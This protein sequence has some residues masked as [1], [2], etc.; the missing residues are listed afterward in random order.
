MSKAETQD[1]AGS[2]I[3]CT[4]EALLLELANGGVYKYIF[5]YFRQTEGLRLRVSVP[6]VRGAQPLFF[7]ST[8]P[9]PL[10]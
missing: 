6:E 2:C 10:P 9:V 8:F 7:T 5:I 1:G 3:R 4:F